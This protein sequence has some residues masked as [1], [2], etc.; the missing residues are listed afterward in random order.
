MNVI[1]YS[2]ARNN[3]KSVMDRVV[4]D[5]EE[6]VITRRNG[7]AVVMISMSEWNSIKETEYLLSN[8]E[9]ARRLREGIAQLDRGDGLVRDLIR[10]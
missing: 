1:S 9:N 10:P 7:E 6:A 8:P 4:E 3:L 2:E 5:C